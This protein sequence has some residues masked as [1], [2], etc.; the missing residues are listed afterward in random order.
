[1]PTQNGHGS[2]CEPWPFRWFPNILEVDA[3]RIASGNVERIDS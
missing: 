1:M 2:S 3:F